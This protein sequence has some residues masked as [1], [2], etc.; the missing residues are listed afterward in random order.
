M[1]DEATQCTEPSTLLPLQL[2]VRAMVL[3]GD[4]RQLPGTVLSPSAAR[5]GLKT[6]LFERIQGAFTDPDA[7]PVFRLCRQYRMNA[8]IC[9]WPNRYFYGGR[10]ISDPITDRMA[11]YFPLLPY[12]IFSLGY[13][14]DEQRLPQHQLYNA[15]EAEFV[16]RLVGMIEHCIGHKNY[17]VGILTPYA[18]QKSELSDLLRETR[19]KNL[20][21]ETIDAYQGQ[22][23]DIVI[24]S[25]TRSQGIGF[26]GMSERLN[27][28]LTRAKRCLIMCGNFGSL[29][30][31]D[32]WNA[33]LDDA[34]QRGR[35][36]RLDHIENEMSFRRRI[37]GDLVK[38]N[39]RSRFDQLEY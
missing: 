39:F 19:L 34:H 38:P 18:R 35:L 33:L 26:L 29:Q 23:R 11:T 5:L 15:S 28:A 12:T 3:V 2:G 4:T 9:S 37:I 6:S 21:I 22:E 36:K 13:R 27:V 7:C 10:L 31:H 8:E 25:N 17:S 14:H 16:V 30:Q 24:V 32:V 1:V 20:T